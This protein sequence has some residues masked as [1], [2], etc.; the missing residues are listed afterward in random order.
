MSSFFRQIFGNGIG[1][2]LVILV[3]MSVLYG[4][5]GV[6]DSNPDAVHAWRQSDCLSITDNYFDNGMVFS[7]PAIHN[8]IS[9]GGKSGKTA[10]EFPGYYY[11]QAA[12]WKVFGKSELS[13]RL[14][15]AFL[16]LLGLLALQ[17][18]VFL[19]FRNRFWSVGAAVFLYTAPALAYYGFGFLSNIPA[20][21][22]ALIGAWFFTKHFVEQKFKW[23]W[24]SALFFALAGLLK[25][26]ALLIYCT[27]GALWILELLGVNLGVGRKVFEKPLRYIFPFAL[28]LIPNFI[29]YSWAA[30]YNATYGG[31]YTFNDLWP[32][33]EADAEYRAWLYDEVRKFT[34]R[35]IFA[36]ISWVLMFVSFVFVIVQ[37]LRKRI[38][39]LVW[40]GLLILFA[41]SF[42]YSILWF[43]AWKDHDYYFLNV[44]ALPAAIWIALGYTLHVSWD[45]MKP[46]LHA[47]LIGFGVVFMGYSIWYCQEHLTL[48]Y[49]PNPN[50]DYFTA[51]DEEEGHLKYLWWDYGR[52]EQALETI[53][54]HLE[55]IGVSKE[56]LVISIPDASF[57]ITLYAM[58]RKGFTNMG[59]QNRDEASIQKHIDLGANFLILNEP[60]YEKEFPFVLPFMEHPLPGYENIRIFDLRPYRD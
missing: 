60:E 44:Y 21:S 24:F 22:F 10:G 29:W 59:D 31:K 2:T 3:L 35:Q 52:H 8:Y 13:Y 49:N 19:L 55:S 53:D 57:C 46:T 15:T 42:V 48:R 33:W 12:I 23:V 4:N 41:G 32:I 30:D 36:P 50:H 39:N 14:T 28:V 38:P 34:A 37:G 5:I 16:F 40:M 56:D 43:Q 18:T 11:V 27:L 7:E 17:Q 54:A 1:V 6:L 20:L 9:E 51:A 45:K 25:V 58:D 47:G 26:T